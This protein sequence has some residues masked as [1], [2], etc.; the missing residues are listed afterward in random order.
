V[1]A[2]KG[3]NSVFC[4]ETDFLAAR[5]LISFCVYRGSAR[6]VA[7]SCAQ[8]FSRVGSPPTSLGFSART[9]FHRT[10]ASSFHETPLRAA[11]FSSELAALGRY[12]YRGL[13]PAIFDSL[14]FASGPRLR[15]TCGGGRLEPL[16]RIN[17][18]NSGFLHNGH[19]R[20]ARSLS[21]GG[22]SFNRRRE[23]R[24]I[25]SIT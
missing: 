11:S 3:A 18:I 25:S 8:A 10:D 12:C 17:S 16:S 20:S 15:H 21:I 23:R 24:S 5:R 1:R 22:F 14:L 9:V 7:P 19:S 2:R 6:R 13:V 4:S